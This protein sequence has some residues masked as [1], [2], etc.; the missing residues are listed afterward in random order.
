MADIPGATQSLVVETGTLGPDR[1]IRLRP[2][3]LDDAELLTLWSSSPRY[4]GEFNDFGL[5]RR[6]PYHE[7]ISKN[8]LTGPDGGTLMV[9]RM[10]LEKR[11]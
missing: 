9:E 11:K 6:R 3:T 7:L 2:V 5:A 1:D 10:A 8:E 4:T